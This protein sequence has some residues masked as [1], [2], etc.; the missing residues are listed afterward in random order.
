MIQLRLLKQYPRVLASPR[1]LLWKTFKDTGTTSRTSFNSQFSSLPQIHHDS[2]PLRPLPTR[3]HSS[4]DHRFHSTASSP[5]S[6][7]ENHNNHPPF[8]PYPII[9]KDDFG[10]NQEYSVIHTDR[11]LNLMSIPFQTVMKDLYH[12]FN[13]TYR[14]AHTIIIP[15]Y[16][17]FVAWWVVG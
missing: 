3:Q 17:L 1:S 7:N 15:G 14:A 11:S 12:C 4:N 2:K 13:H 8:T 5:I 9:P 10:P 6:H 16:V